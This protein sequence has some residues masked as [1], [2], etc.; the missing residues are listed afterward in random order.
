MTTECFVMHSGW[1]A[2]LLMYALKQQIELP[3]HWL[4]VL[5]STGLPPSHVLLP[6]HQ[7]TWSES[8][9]ITPTYHPWKYDS[10]YHCG[11]HLYSATAKY[12]V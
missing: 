4:H 8:N 9:S 7:H 6:A 11:K 1:D 2:L 5:S 3:Q 12:L 10:S